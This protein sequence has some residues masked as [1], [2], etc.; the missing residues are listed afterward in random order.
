M[1]SHTPKGEWQGSTGKK[2]S[3]KAKQ[4]IDDNFPKPLRFIN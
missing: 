4:A 3:A 2:D 1:Y